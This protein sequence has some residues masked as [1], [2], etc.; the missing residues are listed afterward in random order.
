[1]KYIIV[2]YKMQLY[3]VWNLLNIAYYCNK[4]LIKLADTISYSQ[5]KPFD[6]V[7]MYLSGKVR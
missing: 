6:K 4:Y 3:Y 2:I 5:I 7:A 1:M